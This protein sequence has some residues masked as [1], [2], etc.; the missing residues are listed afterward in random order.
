M[1]QCVVFNPSIL[2]ALQLESIL[3]SKFSATMTAVRDLKTSIE[4]DYSSFISSSSV[5]S[6]EKC[7]YM[8]YQEYNQA[9][10]SKVNGDAVHWHCNN[11][12]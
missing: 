8:S 9:F 5:S 6:S 11:C 3:A 12:E 1:W 4:S 7:C 10:R 2:F